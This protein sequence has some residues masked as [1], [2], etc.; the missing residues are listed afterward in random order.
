MK[1][2]GETLI[3]VRCE[4]YSTNSAGWSG[5]QSRKVA[6]RRRKDKKFFIATPGALIVLSKIE[7]ISAYHEQSCHKLL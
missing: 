7:Q 3:D 2:Y 1:T 4:N 5:Q 6:H